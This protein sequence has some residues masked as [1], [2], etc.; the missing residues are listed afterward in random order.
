MSE[1]TEPKRVPTSTYKTTKSSD[2][3]FYII[4][5]SKLI[6]LSKS[7]SSRR[8]YLSRTIPVI[9]KLKKSSQ[10]QCEIVYYLAILKSSV[11]IILHRETR[12]SAYSPKSSKRPGCPP[13]LDSWAQ[14]AIICHVEKYL[15][16]NLHG[17]STPSKLGHTI[18]R[19][20]IWQYLIA[21]GFFG[22]KLRKKF[23]LC[24]KHKTAGLK[25]AKEYHD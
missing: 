19:T 3:N 9:F 25:W 4:I 10:S 21:V 6:M 18:G 24:D 11:T 13:K 7:K 23:F 1:I 8:E 16:D 22:F 2:S 12:R 14:R 5:T 20:I 15:Y 17:L